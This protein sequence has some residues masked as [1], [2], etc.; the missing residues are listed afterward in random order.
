M[1]LYKFPNICQVKIL[2]AAKIYVQQKNFR[3]KKLIE[4]PSR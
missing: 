4:I 2:K 3:K 1:F